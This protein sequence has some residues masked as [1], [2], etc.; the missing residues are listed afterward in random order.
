MRYLFVA[1]GIA[2]SLSL[3]ITPRAIAQRNEAGLIAAWE[4]EQESDSRTTKFEKVADKTYHFATTRFPYDGNLQIVDV[5]IRAP[6]NSGIDGF[7]FS[8]GVIGVQ[9]AGA[10]DDFLKAHE[11]SYTD[12]ESANTLYWDEMAGAWLTS[13]QYFEAVRHRSRV[14]ASSGSLLAFGY[15]GFFRL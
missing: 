13:A 12:W 5:D 9:L 6:L 11:A 1:L 8:P 2:L 7:A 4:A 3:I 10:S 14:T 15:S